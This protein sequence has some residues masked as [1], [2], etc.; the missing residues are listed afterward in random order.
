MEFI[1]SKTVSQN[2]IESTTRKLLSMQ[3][4]NMSMIENH[5]SIIKF[6]LFGLMITGGQSP[7]YL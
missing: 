6:I 5:I 2:L 7:P 4:K 1:G 3:W